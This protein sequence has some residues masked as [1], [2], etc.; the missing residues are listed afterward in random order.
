[1]RDF[2]CQEVP[3]R[4]SLRRELVRSKYKVL[5]YTERMSIHAFGGAGC[6]AVG[7]N[8]DPVERGP[9]PILHFIA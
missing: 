6:S 5:T 9:E 4:G 1:M 7:V 8:A 3:A 2:V